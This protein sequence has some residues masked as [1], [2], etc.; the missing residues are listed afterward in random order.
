M[1]DESAEHLGCR[2]AYTVE[3]DGPPVVLIQGVGVSG[4]GWTPQVEGLRGEFACLTFDNRGMGGSQPAGAPISVRQMAEDAFWLMDRLGW[5][6]AH[7]V[8][9]SLGGPV[10]LEMALARPER[11]RSLSLLCTLARGR[12]AT[13]LTWRMLWLGMSSR[14]GP[15]KARRRAFLHI[16]MPPVMLRGADTER[17]AASLAPLFGH[18]LADQPPIAMK[19]LSALRAYDATDRP[20]EIHVPALVMSAAHDPIA[21]PA[22]GR[23]LAAAIE[24][25]RYVEFPDASHGLPITHAGRV[26]ELLLGH[27]RRAEARWRGDDPPETEPAAPA[28]P[29]RRVNE[30]ST[31]GVSEWQSLLDGDTLYLAGSFDLTYYRDVQLV[32]TGVSRSDVPPELRWPVF[33]APVPIGG[34]VR[35]AIR[36]D[37]GAYEVVAR[38][39]EVR[40]GRTPD[41]NETNR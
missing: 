15:R 14:I 9:H 17:M 21:P 33:D 5:A 25:A 35:Y 11:V 7:V 22:Q 34:D 28:D 24:G 6:S 1:S 30:L 2:F 18:D 32:F 26:N 36:D 41:A 40:I 16:V 10:A 29:L 4:S 39:L 27:L 37:E 8:G 20:G 23:A 19:Q 13:R 12:E 3:G 38:A 31:S